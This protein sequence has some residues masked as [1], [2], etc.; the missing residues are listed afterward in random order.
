M[1][2]N[3]SYIKIKKYCSSQLLWETYLDKWY[4]YP[5]YYKTCILREQSSLWIIWLFKLC[6]EYKDF[7]SFVTWN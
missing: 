7:H 5:Y 4:S 1:F 3:L 6:T 2:Y